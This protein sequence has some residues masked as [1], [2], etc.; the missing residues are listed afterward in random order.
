MALKIEFSD[1]AKHDLRSIRSFIETENE[2]AAERVVLRILQS[3]RHLANFPELGREWSEAGDRAV[4]I[5]GLPYRVHYQ[6]SGE[7]IEVLTIVH[8]RRKHPE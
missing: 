4:S 1:T 5:P 3:I 6:K 8:T 2:K 7:T